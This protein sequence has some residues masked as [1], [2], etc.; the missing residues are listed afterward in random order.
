MTAGVFQLQ[1]IT[2]NDVPLSPLLWGSGLIVHQS[3]FSFFQLRHSACLMKH[4]ALSAIVPLDLFSSHSVVIGLYSCA[5]LRVEKTLIENL[6]LSCWWFPQERKEGK[7]GAAMRK[8]KCCLQG[9]ATSS[10]LLPAAFWEHSSV[11]IYHASP[12]HDGIAS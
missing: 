3:S 2:C 9:L 7:I 4:L 5:P 10:P 6:T 8:L 1:V 12:F 11:S